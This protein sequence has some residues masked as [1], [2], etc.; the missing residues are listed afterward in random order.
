MSPHDE[1]DQLSAYIDGELEALDR[2]RLDAHL[3]GCAECRATLAAL[4]A[5]LA[6]LNELPEPVPT[7]QDS[8]ALRSAI[9]RARRPVRRWQRAAV[10]AGSLAAAAVAVLAF[11]LTGGG[12][13]GTLD[14]SAP[15]RE[16]AGAVSVPILASSENFTLQSAHAHLL[17]VSG[18]VAPGG[19]RALAPGPASRGAA[20]LAEAA[21]ETT[22][23]AA[24]PDSSVQAQIDRCVEVVKRSTQVLLTPVRYEV[25]TFESKPAF[26]LF[27][28]TQD[29]FELWVVSRD[30]CQVLYF[31]QTA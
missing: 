8:W 13:G 28:A 4:R 16:A 1:L 26:F 15:Q 21:K 12:G 31:A 2:T 10:A 14:A 24:I 3:P 29:R 19:A 22:Y 23:S 18:K 5:T 27:F 30:R 25:V 9:A 6:D 17:E 7:E 20:P 11:T